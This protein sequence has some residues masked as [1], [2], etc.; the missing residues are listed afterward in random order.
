MKNP[1]VYL[2]R[3]E[4]YTALQKQV[5]AGLIPPPRYKYFPEL[6]ANAA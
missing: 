6:W 4:K 3:V 5:E 1:D 2:G